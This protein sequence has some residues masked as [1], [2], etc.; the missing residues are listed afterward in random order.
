[1]AEAAAGANPS[2]VSRANAASGD[3]SD[4]MRIAMRKVNMRRV[5]RK[6]NMR[7]IVRKLNMRNE[8]LECVNWK[9]AKI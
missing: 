7:S 6:L 1:V 2:C 5:M 9:I 3:E 8:Q 4:Y